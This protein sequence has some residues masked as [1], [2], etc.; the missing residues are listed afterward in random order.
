VCAPV[1]HMPLLDRPR[2][3]ND[4]RG[5]YVNNGRA[6]AAAGI[7]F[8]LHGPNT[9]HS[10]TPGGRQAWVNQTTVTEALWGPGTV[11]GSTYEWGGGD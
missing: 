11:P 10:E 2:G 4:H 6:L 7:A 8:A 3:D 9:A 1:V 5:A